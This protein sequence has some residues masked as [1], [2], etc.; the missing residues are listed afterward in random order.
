MVT[1]L[2]PHLVQKKLQKIAKKT[3]KDSLDAPV[4]MSRLKN[5]Q[6]PLRKVSISTF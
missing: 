3:L 4:F 1:W 5:A 2:L 6:A